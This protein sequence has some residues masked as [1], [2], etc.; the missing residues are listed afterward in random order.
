MRVAGSAAQSRE[1]LEG[2]ADA[3]VVETSDRRRHQGADERGLSTKRA[4]ADHGIGRVRPEIGDGS[5]VELDAQRMKPRCGGSN[6]LPYALGS[7]TAK[8]H[9]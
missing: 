9:L 3:T 5:E 1:M 2:C 8:L 4:V 6:R 7:S